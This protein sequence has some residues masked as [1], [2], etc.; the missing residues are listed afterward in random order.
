MRKVMILNGPNLDQLG[1]REPE[2]YGN[3]TLAD[4]EALCQEAANEHQFEVDFRQ[5]NDEA[6]LIGW[7]HEA[8]KINLPVIMN[9]AAFTHYS[10]AIRDA[11]AMLSSPLIEVH[12][13]NPIA[14]EEFRHT[15]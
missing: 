4:I 9:P 7:L 15:S 2:L 5:T 13:S 8:A 14:R 6:T 3:L 11:A 1:T 10:V 12:I